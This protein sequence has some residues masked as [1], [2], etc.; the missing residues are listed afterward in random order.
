MPRQQPGLDITEAETGS[1]LYRTDSYAEL[2]AVPSS[3]APT[4]PIETLT[5][6][7]K[8]A[9]FYGHELLD[10]G[11]LQ[12]GRILWAILNTG[13]CCV[14]ANGD[15]VNAFLLLSTYCNRPVAAFVSPLCVLSERHSTFPGS[16]S[17]LPP[18]PLPWTVEFLLPDTLMDLAILEVELYNVTHT[19][20]LMAL[21][22]VTAATTQ[23]YFAAVLAMRSLEEPL[24]RARDQHR[25]LAAINRFHQV[26]ATN[27]STHTLWDLVRTTM[28]FIDHSRRF[29]SIQAH[30][31]H[32][33]FGAGRERKQFAM[34]LA[35]RLLR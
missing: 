20:E 18:V 1:V 5:F 33:W 19:I 29:A 6:Y 8:F 16:S 7:R 24:P 2:S 17:A 9:D 14:L 28:I 10:A 30:Q 25:A 26:Y 22:Q 15:T 35:Y 32:A 23:D 4:Q 34:Q 31:H 12:D 27:A 3:F 21:Q 13:R 11:E